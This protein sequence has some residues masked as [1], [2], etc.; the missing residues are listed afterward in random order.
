MPVTDPAGFVDYDERRHTARFEQ[1]DLLA[2]VIGYSV[3][4]VGNSDEGQLLLAPVS[5]KC[6]SVFRANNHHFGLA[7]DKFLMVLAQLRHVPPAEGSHKSPVENQ[8]QVFMTRVVGEIYGVA[9]K[10][11]EVNV[12]RDLV[13]FTFVRH[14]SYLLLEPGA[15]GNFHLINIFSDM[16]L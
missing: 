14:G 16:F 7:T 5:F 8:D 15:I 6:Q 13:S 4:R 3:I 1:F 10:I 11:D 9:L 2:V 12:K